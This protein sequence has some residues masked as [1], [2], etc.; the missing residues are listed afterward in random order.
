MI[1]DA[2]IEDVF[3]RCRRI[4]TNKFKYGSFEVYVNTRYTLYKKALAKTVVSF[5][6]SI[7]LDRSTVDGYRKIFDDYSS[8][9]LNIPSYP[10]YLGNVPG[11]ISYSKKMYL[12]KLSIPAILRWFI[13]MFEM[14]FLFCDIK[15]R[16]AE[17][18]IM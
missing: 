6:E 10:D 1:T 15:S 16:F 7:F 17:L 5:Y 18:C 11:S 3:T 8:N 4:F 9:S 14:N 12:G 13:L 2:C